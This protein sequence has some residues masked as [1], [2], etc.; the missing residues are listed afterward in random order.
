[1]EWKKLTDYITLLFYCEI[2]LV[3]RPMEAEEE[4]GPSFSPL[5]LRVI[6]VEFHRFRILLT[7]VRQRMT[8][9]HPTFIR[10]HP[11]L[12]LFLIQLYI[13]KNKL[14]QAQN[15]QTQGWKTKPRCLGG[16]LL[17]SA[18]LVSRRGGTAFRW[19]LA[20]ALDS[21]NNRPAA[22]LVYETW[23]PLSDL[24]VSATHTWLLSASLCPS[25]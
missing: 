12:F 14:E 11:V 5:R 22:G 1:M 3:P 19:P 21:R 20:R 7:H 8:S 6:A 16:A 2:S 9:L 18:L 24:L 17:A 25:S 13:T 10:P 4:K 23:W 15:K